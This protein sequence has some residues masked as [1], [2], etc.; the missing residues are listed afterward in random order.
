M[1]HKV[2]QRML[3]INDGATKGQQ[4]KPR[5][6]SHVGRGVREPLAVHLRAPAR[7]APSED[8]RPTVYRAN[9][10]TRKERSHVDL[11]GLDSPP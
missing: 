8:L 11:F 6:G 2:H 3:G 4:F 7:K 5:R 9:Q 10:M 1:E